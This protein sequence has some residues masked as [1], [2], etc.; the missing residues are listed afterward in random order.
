MKI[1]V[2][3]Q[4]LNEELNIARFCK[5]YGFADHILITDCSTDSTVEI[6]QSFKNVLI[7]DVS[8]LK[9]PLDDPFCPYGT[10]EGPQR[11][12]LFEWAE[13][14][15]ADWIVNDD[16]DCWPNKH[17]HGQARAILEETNHSLVFAHRF[18]MWGRNQYFPKYNSCGQA[19]WAWNIRKHKMAIKNDELWA[20]GFTNI[21]T[22][23]QRRGLY[24]EPPLVLL[25]HF[26]QSEKIYEMKLARKLA[27]GKKW[28]HP[29]RSIYAPPQQRPAYA[30]EQYQE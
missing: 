11:E 28:L 16:C 25:H 10:P 18:Y 19:I 5:N 20:T 27:K 22:E 21:R 15:G 6:A 8:Y 14:L 26:C 3:V 30:V 1:V 29:L 13:K 2:I 17:L 4:T 24:L 9:K 12:I 23:N 7:R